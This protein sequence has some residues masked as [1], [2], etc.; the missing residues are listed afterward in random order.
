MESESRGTVI[1]QLLAILDEAFSQ[2]VIS[3]NYFTDPSPESGYFGVLSRLDA[4]G[5]ARLVGGTS[6]AS[7]IGHITF[8][9]HAAA[10]F[11]QGNPDAPGLERWRQSWQVP[12]MDAETWAQMQ[13]QLRDAYHDLRRAIEFLDASQIQSLGGAIGAIAHVA[14]HLG[15]IK[16]KLAIISDA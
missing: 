2:P 14:Y 15:A 13:A 4:S 3:W 8:A 7:Q 16:Q 5:A 12:K 9:M 1:G 6:V 10:A 11:I